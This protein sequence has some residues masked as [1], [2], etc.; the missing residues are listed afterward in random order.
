[1]GLFVEN[2]IVKGGDSGSNGDNRYHFQVNLGGMLDL[3]SNH[4]YKSP[5]VF[6]RELLQNGVDAI[7]MR[8]KTQ[9]GWH[10]GAITITVE[11][12]KRIEF[13]DNGAGLTQEEIHRFLAVIGQSSK[14]QL[15]NGQIPEDYIGR[16]GIGLLSC[17]MVSDSIVVY[18][19]PMDGSQ[20]NIWTGFPD[21][22]Y[23]LAPLAMDKTD[24][25]IGTTVILEAKK[26][27]EHYFQKEKVAELV[28][29]YGLVLPI[30]VYMAGNP[31]RLNHVPSDFS[32]LGRRQLL[33]FGNWLFDEEFLDA[34]P[35]QT[36]HLRGVAYILSYRT[37]SSMK[38]GHR[39]YL[40]QMLLTEEGNTL[41]PPWAFFMRCFLNTRNLRPTASREDF[42][43]DKELE[44]ARKEFEETIRNY[45]EGL[46]QD[47]QERLADIVNT[48]E[49]AIKSMAVWD[50]RMFCLFIDYLP[51]ETSEGTCTGRFLKRAGEAEWIRSVPR[52]QQ[53]K[54]LFIAQGRLLI[55]TGYTSDEELIRKLTTMFSL[56]LAP[57]QEGSM[58]LVLE[59]LHPFEYLNTEFFSAIA[60][61]AVNKF[62]CR[63]EI[64]RFLPTDLP[65][66]Y[67]MSDEIQFLRQLQS[68]KDSPSNLFSG[69]LS[70]LIDSVEE[71]PLAALYFN[72][73]SSLVQRLVQITDEALIKS[74]VRVLYVQALLAGGY[75]LNG[76]ELKILNKELLNLVEYNI[77]K[78]F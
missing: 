77:D 6:I 39:I 58:D 75:P 27:E 67:S 43:E 34:I 76:G 65:V 28:R 9:P 70:S 30:P 68:A 36:P 14:T 64:K 61:Q 26:G 48:H 10:S 17:F 1:M 8:Q 57:F 60:R 33:S 53:L 23:T 2:E 73:N 46:A 56:P 72:L 15:V 52:F 13:S 55:C 69:A 29:Y 22:T 7:T 54:P 59:E 41:L 51:F 18:T 71:K 3:L 21:G 12:G 11:Q 5:D 32:G 35:V 37:D 4:L 66:L 25:V 24:K 16:F 62:D 74:T 38:S 47:S 20:A 63:V 19:I 50:D 40:K 49:Q 44:I 78:T 31:E 42:Y 45:L